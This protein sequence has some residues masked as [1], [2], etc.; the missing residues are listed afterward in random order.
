MKKN[1]DLFPEVDSTGDSS[2]FSIEVLYEDSFDD[3][4]LDDDNSW[5]DEH[6]HKR[7][8]RHRH[9]KHKRRHSLKRWRK[10]MLG[11]VAI[12]VVGIAGLTGGFFY[13][14]AQGEKNLKT[15]VPDAADSAEAPEG[16]F[17]TYNGKKYQY[18]ENVINFLCMGIDKDLPIEEKR[19]TGS[20]GLSDANILISINV[21]TGKIKLLA[22]PRDTIVP[23]KV[24]DSA[25]YF[26]KNEN[27]QLTLQYAY[28]QSAT[29]SCELMVDTVSNL[30]FQLPI[31]RYCS[32][33]FEAIPILNDAIG[34]VDVQALEEIKI[35]S[36]TYQQGEMI[37]LQGDQTLEYVRHRDT[38]VFGSSMGRLERQKQYISNYFATA[39]EV[40]KSNMTLPVT[41]YQNLQGKMC[42]N[43]TVEDIAYLV[44]KLLDVNLTG[45]DM[46]VVPGEIIQPGD[47]E[48]Y[49]VNADQLKEIVINNFYKEIP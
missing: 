46:T 45:E 14:R 11:L 28:G 42:T 17:V 43:I 6:G 9:E 16:L 48:E 19:A 15:E 44:P 20:E 10:V 23:V 47:H 26:V 36:K 21:E 33:N 1:N 34:G 13:L 3:R 12:I 38:N 5:D 24:V 32:V 35:G 39:K 31:Q 41:I 27:Q 40:V 22:I 49:H 25:G 8:H 30:L 29:A 18:D 4:P 37:H 7:R 2:D